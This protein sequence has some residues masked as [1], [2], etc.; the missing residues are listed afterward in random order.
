M[1]LSECA[2]LEW[3]PA[4]RRFLQNLE[5]FVQNDA[6]GLLNSVEHFMRLAK[7]DVCFVLHHSSH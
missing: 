4:A 7:A 1:V 2:F 5:L 6:F 3:F